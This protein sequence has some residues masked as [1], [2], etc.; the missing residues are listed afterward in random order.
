MVYTKV[1]LSASPSPMND[2]CKFNES[3]WCEI[4]LKGEDR[5]LVGCV[6]RSPNS[7]TSNN[8][9]LMQDLKKVSK[10]SYSHILICGDFNY[11]GINWENGHCSGQVKIFSEGIRDSYFHQHVTDP[12]HSRPNQQANIL[13]LILTNEEGM[14]GH[15]V[16]SA[17]LGKSHHSVLLFTLQVYKEP[18]P[19]KLRYFFFKGDYSRMSELLKRVDLESLLND[20]VKRHGKH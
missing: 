6:Y 2:V 12:T 7:S 8:F 18:T 19:F 1:S 11:P 4:S 3:C 20:L 9:N 16:H 5:L 10:K 14:I 15:I 13:D 17:P